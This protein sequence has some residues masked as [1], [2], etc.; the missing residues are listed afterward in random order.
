MMSELSSRPTNS[1]LHKNLHKRAGKF[2][3]RD[4]ALSN[5]NILALVDDAIED[6]ATEEAKQKASAERAAASAPIPAAL[7]KTVQTKSPIRSK[8]RS[9]IRGSSVRSQSGSQKSKR[10]EN[11]NDET[12][13][14]RSEIGNSTRTTSSTSSPLPA[15]KARLKKQGKKL[16]YNTSTERNKSNNVAESAP[17]TPVKPCETRSIAQG[18]NTSDQSIPAPNSNFEADEKTNALPEWKSSRTMKVST[19]PNTNDAQ[20]E[21]KGKELSKIDE[22]DPVVTTNDFELPATIPAVAQSTNNDEHGER[23]GKELS[24]VKEVAPVVTTNAI[25]LPKSIPTVPKHVKTISSTN[26]ERSAAQPIGL[27]GREKQEIHTESETEIKIGADDATARSA[28]SH[29]FVSNNHN[30]ETKRDTF[31]KKSDSSENLD[32]SPNERSGIKSKK[33]PAMTMNLNRAVCTEGEKMVIKE[34]LTS[35]IE[36]SCSQTNCEGDDIKKTTGSDNTVLVRL[37]KEIEETKQHLDNVAVDAN[38]DLS[39]LEKQFKSAKETLRFRVMKKINAQQRENAELSEDY[40][41]EVEEQQRELDEV[42]LANQRLRSAIDKLPKQMAEVKCSNRDLEI[43]NEEIAGHFED[44]EKFVKKLQSDQRQL[45]ESNNK[46]K[47]VFLP[48]YRQELWE[49]QQYLEAETKIKNLYRDCVI[50]ATKRIEQSR[51][52]ELIQEVSMMVIETEGEVNPKFDPKFLFNED[53]SD[54]SSID[55]DSDDSDYE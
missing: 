45:L 9:P 26:D 53:T 18:K 14:S 25:E 21:E 44:L 33:K 31:E 52:I 28:Y 48:R 8:Q 36:K 51:Q 2:K 19:A 32:L 6:G 13:G 27:R 1:Y 16:P 43:A 30:D 42:R 50:K 7:K 41:E 39:E 5:V 17:K 40:Q 12:Q 38:R 3:G 37:R 11:I 35:G 23:R 10:K 55:S 46:C 4:T 47:N 15:W 20:G 49:R 29:S 24:K 54:D 34:K 22:V